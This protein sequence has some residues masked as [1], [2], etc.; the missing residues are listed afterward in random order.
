MKRSAIN[1]VLVGLVASLAVA[2]WL[3][4]TDDHSGAPTSLT[5][6]APGKIT[7]IQRLSR[8]GP[9]LRMVRRNEIW[10]MNEP[11]ALAANAERVKRLLNVAAAPTI[12]QFPMP[13]N[14]LQEFGLDA[15]LA[16]LEL[17]GL[18]LDFGNTDPIKHHRYVRFEGKLHLIKDIYA[19]H[20]T[21]PAEAFVSPRLFAEQEKILAVRTPGWQ[22][23][24]EADGNWRMTPSVPGLPQDQLA[25]KI[26]AWQQSEA[27]KVEAVQA[28]EIA[29]RVEILLEGAQ[30]P[31]RFAILSRPDGTLLVRQELGLGYRL[32]ADSE[33]L[34]VPGG[35][36]P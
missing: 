10:H 34:I 35:E 14:R 19:H 21:A 28:E 7:A 1:L 24:R 8:H 6:L 12:E 32:P 4:P 16:R 26:R 3:T 15:P 30:D 27:L 2:V 31:L 20:L 18:A 9:A 17:N 13:E 29:Q 11:Y 36:K 5:P 22:L 23:F 25:S 33:L